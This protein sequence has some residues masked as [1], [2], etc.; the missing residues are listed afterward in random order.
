M[1]SARQR[2]EAAMA[3]ESGHKRFDVVFVDGHRRQGVVGRVSA[4]STVANTPGKDPGPL[5]PRGHEQ[6]RSSPPP[7][8]DDD[9]PAPPQE[10]SPPPGK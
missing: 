10:E 5:Q 9:A 8:Y 4:G 3:A 6:L 7:W 1:A 2:I